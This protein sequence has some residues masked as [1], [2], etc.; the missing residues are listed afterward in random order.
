MGA[1]AVPTWKWV[2]WAYKNLITKI[3][4]NQMMEDIYYCFKRLYRTGEVKMWGGTIANVPTG[5]LTCDGSAISRG[6][7]S[8]LFSIIGT[9][10]GVGDGS[11]TFNIPDLRDKFLIGAKQDDSGVPKSN[12][13]GSLNQSGGATTHSHTA[14]PET[15]LHGEG[16]PTASPTLHVHPAATHIPPYYTMVYIIK[17]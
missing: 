1:P 4:M 17:T 15:T 7:Y 10:H 9:I 2:D 12:I 11:T 13:E 14:A 16:G 8:T 6:T 3:K 5:F